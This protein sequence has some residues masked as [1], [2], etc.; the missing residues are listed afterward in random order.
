MMRWSVDLVLLALLLVCGICR[1]G[2]GVGGLCG[3]GA[4]GQGHRGQLVHVG[5]VDDDQLL[6]GRLCGRDDEGT[7]RYSVKRV[8]ADAAVFINKLLAEKQ[9][10][11]SKGTMDLLWING[12]NFKNAMENGLL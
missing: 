7:I 8:P 1:P 12:E 6:G 3:D 2:G 5:R 4:A 9:A 10:G 11:G